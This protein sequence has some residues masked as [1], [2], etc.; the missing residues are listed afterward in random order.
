MDVLIGCEYSGIVRDAFA[1]KGH[2]AWSCDLLASE[3]PGQHLQCDIK[4]AIMS[5]SWDFIGLHLPCTK[6]ALCGNKHYGKGMPKNKERIEAMDWTGTVYELAKQFSYKGYFENPKNVMGA[7]IGKK[8]QTIQPYQFGHLEQ[9]ETWLWLWGLPKLVETN[10]VY[11][12]MM[13]LPKQERERIFHMT[14]SA[15]RGHERSRTYTGI[16]LA[17]AE[18][19]G[20]NAISY[21]DN[22]LRPVYTDTKQLLTSLPKP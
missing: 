16:A 21:P 7:V 8:T 17:M 2:N 5:R 13:K 18:Q 6:I 19:W 1:A 4:E 14:P 20:Q 10:N 12:E 22:Q 11:D 3:R 15:D 9:K